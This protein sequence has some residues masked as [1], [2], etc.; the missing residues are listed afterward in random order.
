MSLSSEHRISLILKHV[1]QDKIVLLEGKLK[2]EEEAKL[3]EKTMESISP[4]F[5]GIELAV[6]GS[7]EQKTAFLKALK[8]NV[9]HF[10]LGDRQGMT[11]V[12]PAS[13]VKEIK[14]DPSNIQLLFANEKK[15]RGR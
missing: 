13:L 2:K 1:Q 10:L 6:L 5:K 12:G 11:I 9:L 4:K 15:R 3:I 7:Q 14:Q 8:E